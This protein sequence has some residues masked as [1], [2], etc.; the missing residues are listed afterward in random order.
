LGKH[1]PIEAAFY[2]DSAPKNLQY[3]GEV[4]IHFLS[5]GSPLLLSISEEAF[6]ALY[7]DM[8]GQNKFV[9][10]QSLANQTVA[11]RTK[12]ISD[13]YFSSEAYDDFGPEHET[14]KYDAHVGLQLPDNRD[15]EIVECL[16]SDDGYDEFDEADVRRVQSRIMITEDQ[17][18][19]LLADGRIK[20]ENLEE[21]RKKNSIETDRIFE[22]ANHVVY[23][24]STG[25]RRSV[26]VE[27][28]DEDLYAAFYPL[29][30]FGDMHEDDEM[31]LFN[32]EGY[33]RAIFINP[34]ALDY[35]S[36]P[37]HKFEAG[38]LEMAAETLDAFDDDDPAPT[39]AK[40]K[41]RKKPA[42]QT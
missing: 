34:L 40:P 3:Y 38:S 13:L 8:Q 12:A 24:L 29:V 19:E 22:L 42:P 41:S 35:V 14:G 28:R 25:E 20:A 11:I 18:K 1:P 37:T 10:V 30:E 33:H 5:G 16:F 17:Y 7:R 39:P 15:W 32:N 2:D 9:T 26:F 4:A 36:V 27:G 23:Q 6:Q 21:E 31:I